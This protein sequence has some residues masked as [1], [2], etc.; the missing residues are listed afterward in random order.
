MGRLFNTIS[1]AFKIEEVKDRILFTLVILAIFRLGVHIPVPGVDAKALASLFK[2]SKMLGFLDLFVGG[3]LKKFSIFALG[4]APYI[5]ASIIMQLLI[6]VV[7][8]LEKMS[9]DDEGRKKINIYTK[10]ATV[11]I[12]ALQALG[13]TFML[14]NLQGGTLLLPQMQQHFA[15]F[16]ILSVI[17]LTA[18]TIFLMWLG[19]QITERGISNGISLLIYAGIVARI[20]TAVAQTWRQYADQPGFVPK[21]I[22]ILALIVLITAAV[23]FMQE[24]VR[25]IPIKYGRRVHGRR[26]YGGHTT[27]LPI[28]VN[29]GGVIP[30]IFAMSVVMFPTM[31]GEF[32]KNKLAPGSYLSQVIGK[33]L[34]YLAPGTWL[35]FIL[36]AALIIFF[37]FFYASIIFNPQDVAENL[38]KYGGMVAG[39]RPGKNT[40]EYLETVTMRVTLGGSIFLALIAITP[41]LLMKFAKVPFYFGGTALLIVVGVALDV[42]KQLEAHLVMRYYDGITNKSG[43]LL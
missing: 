7:P 32:I 3:A 39:R 23:V 2:G 26:V 18:G 29:M 5:N 17:T 42:V 38:K 25:K 13:I 6:Y 16:A 10:Y 15:Y 24:G 28:K 19:D 1:N 22:V 11:V 33:I 21:L 31:I 36:Y 9:K 43:G 41:Y 35:Y 40:A 34:A 4:V 20:P 37:T 12:A 30:I 27:Y 8:A 14:R